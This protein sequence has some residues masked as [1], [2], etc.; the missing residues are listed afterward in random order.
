MASRGRRLLATAAIAAVAAVAVAA[1][2]VVRHHDGRLTVH[3][4]GAA[5]GPLLDDIERATGAA[6]RGEAPSRDVSV[7]LDEVPIGDALER[8]LGSENFALRYGR[9]GRLRVIELLSGPAPAGWPPLITDAPPGT[10]PGTSEA[11][12]REVMSRPLPVS[13]RL[14]AALGTPRPT[15]GQVIQ[16]A[17]RR[18]S[19]R[20]RAEAQDEALAAFRRDPELEA[21]FLAVLAPIED[22]DLA[23]VLGGMGGD[24]AAELFAR[25]ATQAPSPALRAKA[26]SALEAFRRNEARGSPAPRP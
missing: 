25:L 7:H 23:R 4:D 17:L 12:Q 8:L 9:D 5:L 20:V 3:A 14:G 19:A 6:V 22:D 10:P 21:T 2:P 15:A 26:A 1:T 24:R 18:P 16:A 13:R 11:Q